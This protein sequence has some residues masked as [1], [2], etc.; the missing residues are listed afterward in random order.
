MLSCADAG[1]A[2]GMAEALPIDTAPIADAA[3]KAN[4]KALIFILRS[5]WGT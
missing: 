3:S 5:A 4:E 1:F 2:N